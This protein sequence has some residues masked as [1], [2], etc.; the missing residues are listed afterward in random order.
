MVFSRGDEV[1]HVATSCHGKYGGG[2][3]ELGGSPDNTHPYVVYHKDGAGTHC[4]RLADWSNDI[5]DEDGNNLAEN[6]TGDFVSSRLVGWNGWPE[7]NVAWDALV[8]KWPS[9]VSP[10]IYDDTFAEYL[11]KAAGDNVPGFD[12]EIDE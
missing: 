8:E 2:M 9:G 11:R 7:D 1:I 12:P 10:K 6:P 4:W 3:P 5:E